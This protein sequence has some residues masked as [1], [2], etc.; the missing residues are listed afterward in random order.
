M[1]LLVQNGYAQPS[2]ANNADCE[3]SIIIL[4]HER[5]AW[6]S[7]IFVLSMLIFHVFIKF[8]IDLFASLISS[9]I[10]PFQ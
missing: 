6:L 3:C 1:S 9:Y 8:S 7:I 4:F 2:I 5:S 10:F